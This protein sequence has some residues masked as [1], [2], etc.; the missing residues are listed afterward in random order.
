[1]A[2]LTKI[3]TQPQSE[4]PRRAFDGL[5]GAIAETYFSTEAGMKELGWNGGI[6]FAPPAG[7]A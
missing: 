6:T 5:K 2:L 1:M 3:S 7:C 4:M